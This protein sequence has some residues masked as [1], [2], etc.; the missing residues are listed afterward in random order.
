MSAPFARTEEENV[1]IGRTD[2][3]GYEVGMKDGT[4]FT[5]GEGAQ[6]SST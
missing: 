1:Q 6:R 3:S 4:S 5:K 2:F